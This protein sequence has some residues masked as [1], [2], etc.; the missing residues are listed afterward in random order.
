LTERKP[1]VPS[2]PEP[3]SRMP[4][5]RWPWSSA[6]EWNRPSIG[7][8]RPVAAGG[9]TRSTPPSIVSI[10]FGGI[11]YTWSGSTG[12]SSRTCSTFMRVVLPSSSGISVAWCGSRCCTT[13]KDMPLSGGIAVKN[14]WKASSPPAEAPIPTTGGGGG[15]AKGWNDSDASGLRDAPVVPRAALRATARCLAAAGF[16][17][18]ARRLPADLVGV[19]IARG[20]V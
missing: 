12:V 8:R 13:T 11:T 10:A 17:V 6:S 3:D 15:G 18:A 19:A 16:R 5:V 2:W 7:I 9:F 1:S 14:F 20:G 4:M